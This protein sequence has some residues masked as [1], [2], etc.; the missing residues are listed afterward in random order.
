MTLPEFLE[1]DDG[2]FVHMTGHRIGLHH[3]VRMYVDGSS[4]ETIAAHYPSLPLALVH[5]VIA[6][7]LDNQLDVDAYAVA[8][9]HEIAQEIAAAPAV[10]SVVELRK[11]LQ[12]MG[13]AE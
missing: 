9:D 8:H 7:Y 3:V 6:F 12:R 2:G 5:R 4:P 1:M 10:P 11:R 13:A